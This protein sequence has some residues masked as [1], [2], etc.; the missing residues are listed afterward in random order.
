M[1]DIV[2]PRNF[3]AYPYQAEVFKAFFVEKKRRFINIW[4]RRA[5]KD[6]TWFNIAIAATQQKVGMYLYTL[7]TLRQ[8]RKVIWDGID[9]DGFPFLSHIPPSII[10]GK[11]NKVDMKIKFKNGSILQ[12]GGSDNYNSLVGTNPLGI[13]HSEFSLQNPLAWEYLRPILTQNKGWAA[14]I[15]TPRGSNHAYK[16]YEKAKENK[17]WYRNLLT[18]EDTFDKNGNR[19][20]TDEMIEEARNNGMSDQMI[21]QEFYCSFTSAL[22]GAYFAVQM[23]RME[24]QDR[25]KDFIIRTDSLV[26]SFWDLG[27][28]DKTAI[29]LM[30]YID[31]TPHMIMYY[32]NHG[33]G[34]PH[35]INFLHDIR[36]KYGFI[37]GEH[38]LPHDG[39][40]RDMQTGKTRINFLRQLGLN[41][42]RLVKKCNRKIDAIEAA[43]YSLDSVII[44]KIN[45]K[46]GIACLR[47]Y[48]SKFNNLIGEYGDKVVHNWAS[49]GADAFMTYAQSNVKK[50]RNFN[51][52][53]FYNAFNIKV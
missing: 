9:K 40:N 19:I 29:W 13:I 44:H 45:C 3:K 28:G 52:Q 2:L 10:K 20:I 32:E 18:V 42:T 4:H 22:E 23:S 33:F 30:Q 5:G 17:K 37:Y 47:E 31:N 53:T 35:Y 25:I 11:P 51:E 36:N 41:P 39:I 14:F 46:Q 34:L 21:Q 8:A 38:Y 27:I 48:H 16:V 24:E 12:L 1:S 43:R 49:H 15:C 50:N 26:Y 7:P 6:K